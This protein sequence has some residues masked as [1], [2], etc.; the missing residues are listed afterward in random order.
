[1][2]KIRSLVSAVKLDELGRVILPD[3]VIS[4]IEK[5]TE[6]LIAGANLRCGGTSNAAC[7]NGSCNGSAN[8]ACS[9]MVTCGQATNVIAC[10]GGAVQPP[11]NSGCS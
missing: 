2:S 3:E 7:T 5:H 10:D 1:M 8:M 11:T 9:N 6:C 4:E